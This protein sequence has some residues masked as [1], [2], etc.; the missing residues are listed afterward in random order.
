MTEGYGHPIFETEHPHI[1]RVEGV[2]GGQPIVR[3]KSVTVQT[4]VVLT[5]QNV[6]PEQLVDEYDGVL[7]LAEVY[8]ALSYYHDHQDEIDQY[9]AENQAARERGWQPPVSS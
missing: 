7:T 2:Q 8:D 6:N 3:G 4:I 1:I 5:K 9:I